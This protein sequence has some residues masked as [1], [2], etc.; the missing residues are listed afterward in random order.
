MSSKTLLAAALAALAAL[1]AAACTPMQWVKADATPGEA[2]QDA[3]TCQQD[4]WREARS[5]AW[6]YAPFGAVPFRDRLGRQMFGWPHGPY[7][8]DPFGDPYLEEARL[9]QFCMRNKG[10]QLEAAPAK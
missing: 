8:G 4:A 1:A 2:E 7:A 3:I 9:A 5:R 6:F 10:Y